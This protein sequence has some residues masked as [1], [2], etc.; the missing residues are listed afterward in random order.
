MA[1]IR[2]AYIGGGSTRAPGTLVSFTEQGE[3]FE[4]SEVVLTD[5]DEERLN[6][7]MI[8]LNHGCW[9]V[10]HPYNGEDAIPLIREAFERK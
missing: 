8:G 1:R 9:S 6:A 10:R 2:L 7:I 3:N 4:G 5:L